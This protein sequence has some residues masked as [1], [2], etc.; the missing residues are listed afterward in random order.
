M[1]TSNTGPTPQGTNALSAVASDIERTPLNIATATRL[2][3]SADELAKRSDAQLHSIVNAAREHGVSWQAIG[4]ALGVSRQAA[5]KRFSVH[6]AEGNAM[7]DPIDLAE[8]TN[9]I[10]HSLA[11]G[12]YESVKSHMTYACAREL[13]KRKLMGVW[14]DVESE[15]GPLER[16]SDFTAQTPD[17]Q[18]ALAQWANR[19]TLSG[20]IVQTTL[21]HEAGEW[22]ARVAYNSAGKILAMY[23]AP[24]GT[25]N[26]PF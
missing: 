3:R 22:M 26:L 19:H 18:N 2:I 16:C 6:Q 15:S 9:E 1:E 21:H 25:K 20:S 7:S 14:R 11:S 10:F 8:R 12:D 5:F 13:S 23:I 24:P 17:G 4:E